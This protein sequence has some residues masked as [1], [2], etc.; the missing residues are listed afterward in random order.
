MKKLIASAGLVAVGTASLHAAADDG[1]GLTR[2]EASKPWSIS[3]SLRGFYDDNFLA[4]PKKFEEDSWGMEF[5]PAFALNFPMETSY[6]HLGYIYS[7]RYYFDRDDENA[8]HSHDFNLKAEHRFSERYRV[9]LADSFVFAQEPEVVD[10]TTQTQ[11]RTD[12]DVF[13]NRATINFIAQ[14]T[15]LWSLLAGYQNLWYDYSQDGAFSRSALLDRMEHLFRLDARWQAKEHLIG[16]IGYQYGV[17]DYTSK[18]LITSVARG[19]DRDNTA[20]YVYV[21]ANYS[22]SSQLN[23]EARLGVRY[24]DYDAGDTETSPYADVA[25]TYTYL[26]GSYV[27]LGVRHDRNATDIAGVGTDITQDQESTT[28][29]GSLNH[30]ITPHLNGRLEAHYQR[31]VFNGGPDDGDVD[32]FFLAGVNLEYRINNNWSAET[33]Y[34]F[35]RL[36]SDATNRSFTRNR[37][38]VGVRASY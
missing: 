36:D 37:V 5:S 9:E 1:Y 12:S 10:E 31:G 20:H 13:R 27:Q 4:A 7:L 29:S 32:N 38:Y 26:P 21:G 24:T 23:A 8:D 6:L 22:F 3:A 17:N 16:L 14:L 30:R 18:D 11:F 34:N 28:V 15:E 25:G 35:D 33:G 2:Q 19:D